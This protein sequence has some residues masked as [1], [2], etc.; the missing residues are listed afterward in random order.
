MTQ[1]HHAG[2][3]RSRPLPGQDSNGV[4]VLTRGARTYMH[5]DMV[6][7]D[8]SVHLL[9][10][11]P[12]TPF[13]GQDSNGVHVLTRGVST[14][15]R[16]IDVSVH[17][18]LQH[19]ASLHG[20]PGLLSRVSTKKNDHCLESEVRPWVRPTQATGAAVSL[21]AKTHTHAHTFLAPLLALL[22]LQQ[23]NK[24][25]NERTSKQ[26]NERTNEQ[27]SKQ[28]SEAPPLRVRT[29]ACMT[30]RPATPV[31]HLVSLSSPKMGPTAPDLRTSQIIS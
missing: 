3:A 26:A 14:H 2:H 17:C 12:T 30:T 1:K 22:S 24:Q 20:T 4:R 21:A 31:L 27:A 25:T 16:A 23:T 29:H 19:P 5:A 7:V 6:W 28:T 8:V 18:L 9:L 15:T 13:P 11:H 10:R